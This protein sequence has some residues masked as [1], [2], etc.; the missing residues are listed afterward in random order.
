[1]SLAGCGD[2]SPDTAAASFVKRILFVDDDESLLEGLRDALR[3]YRRRWQMSFVNSGEAALAVLASEPQDVIVCDLRM[4][5]LDGA[6]VLERTREMSPATV[7]IVLSGHADVAMVSRAAAA[8]HRLVAKPCGTDEL[9]RILERSCALQDVAAR[10]EM[11]PRTIG[12]SALPSLPR[13]YARLS[14]MLRGGGASGAEI[15]EVISEDIAMAAKVLQLANSAYFGRRRPTANLT[16]A[17][18]YLGTDTLRALLLHA[19]AFRAFPVESPIPRFSLDELQRHCMRVARLAQAIS[20]EVGLAADAFTAGLLHDIGLLIL[21]A[22]APDDLATTLARAANEHRSIAEVERERHG[23][24]HADIGAHLLSLWG[25]PHTVTEAIAGHHSDTWL[26][27]PFDATAAVH[28][29]EALIEQAEAGTNSDA[30]PA[31]DPDLVYLTQAGV[32]GRIETWRGLA[33]TLAS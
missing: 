12:A 6:S 20:K 23:V 32:T 14:E 28:I 25:L 21:A 27:L 13:A 1:M 29:A 31:P 2:P 3:P 30:S 9:T 33:K 15:A 19:E 4:P 22:R 7:R 18:A 11:D 10:V 8:A 24:T 5:G 17:V 26:K 16:D